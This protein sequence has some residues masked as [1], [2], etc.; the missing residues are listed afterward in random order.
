VGTKMVRG[1]RPRMAC[2]SVAV[3]TLAAG[4]VG[5]TDRS[6]FQQVIASRGGGV[7]TELWMSSL[8]AVQNH[9]GTDDF[10]IRDLSLKGGD[11]PVVTLE[12]RDPSDADLL[13]R[14]TVRGGS[15]VSSVDPVIVSANESLGGHL[16]RVSELGALDNL[17]AMVDA[18]LLEFGRPD[19]HVS[20]FSVSRPAEGQAVVI[21]AG[22][23][24]DRATGTARFTAD[25]ELIGVERA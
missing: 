23:E 1:R 24:S 20:F 19:G 11:R 25:G 18:A 13:D 4:C 16:F 14:Y 3:A 2:L 22:L 8:D 15:D 7:T 10:E 9:L 12:I 6:D 5:A 17:D 21:T